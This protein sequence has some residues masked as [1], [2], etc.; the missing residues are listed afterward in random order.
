MAA[1]GKEDP[2]VMLMQ[3]G[4][5]RHV[6]ESEL[7]A[8]TSQRVEANGEYRCTYVYEV[9]NQPSGGRAVMHGVLDVLTLGIWEVVGTPLEAVQGSKQQATVV[10]HQTFSSKPSGSRPIARQPV[11][12]RRRHRASPI[13]TNRGKPLPL[14]QGV[15]NG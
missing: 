13:P 14:L 4:T 1:S 10:T 2:N 8:P 7:G 9:G 11:P 6:V 3:P 5:P 12:L 15:R